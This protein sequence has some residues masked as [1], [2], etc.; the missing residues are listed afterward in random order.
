MSHDATSGR[1]NR[2]GRIIGLSS[3][4]LCFFVIAK[5]LKKKKKKKH[6]ARSLNDNNMKQLINISIN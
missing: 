5:E 6:V 1:D 4:V 3:H 2:L